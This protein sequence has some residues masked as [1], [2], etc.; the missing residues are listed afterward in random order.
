MNDKGPESRDRLSEVFL[1]EDTIPRGADRDR[2]RANGRDL[3]SCRGERVRVPGRDDGP[4]TMTISQEES[5][6]T[7]DVRTS[8]GEQAVSI[9]VSMTPFRPL[10]KDYFLV[11]ET[12]YSAIRTASP[13]QIEAIDRER[14][15]LHNEGAELMAQRLV[16]EGDDRSGDRAPALHPGLD[17][18]LED[19]IASP[20]A[21]RDF[22]LANTRLLAPPLVPEIRLWLADEAVPIWEKTEEELGAIGLCR[23]P[24]GPS[25]GRA[26]RRSPAMRLDNP[27]WC[28]AGACSTSPPAPAS[29][30]SPRRRRGSGGDRSLGHRRFR[31]A[32]IEANAAENRAAVS[33]RLEDLIGTD[34]GWDVVLAGDVAYEKDMADAVDRLARAARAARRRP[35]SSAIRAAPTSPSTASR[36]SSN[37]AFR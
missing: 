19:M 32:A 21:R 5:K 16:G 24:S 14:T 2:S 1:D 22:V 6:L 4:Y 3:R 23:R 35:C 25:P 7:F 28:A 33:A 31:V 20:A 11:C 15:K 27:E 13:R 17:L 36:A 34:E 10:L 18:A 9:V 30:P 12:Y 37:I 26:A 8:D 29:S